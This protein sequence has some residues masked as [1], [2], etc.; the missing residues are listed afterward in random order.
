MVIKAKCKF[1]SQHT[2]HVNLNT[3]SEL[4]FT[5]C[6]HLFKLLIH[7]NLVIKMYAYNCCMQHK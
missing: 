4:V 3:N 5:S 1:I 7:E 2:Y 6:N